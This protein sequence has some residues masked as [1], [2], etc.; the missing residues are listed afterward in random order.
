MLFALFAVLVAG[1]AAQ[2]C[3]G[4]VDV[5]E[6]PY[7]LKWTTTGDAESTT[8]V[9]TVRPDP[10]PTISRRRRGLPSPPRPFART[11]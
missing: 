10:I 7:S 3:K 9:V 2:G 1:A 5:A 4:D 11:I 8:F 6:L